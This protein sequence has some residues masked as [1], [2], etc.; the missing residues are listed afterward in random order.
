M[1]KVIVS[2]GIVGSLTIG[3]LFFLHQKTEEAISFLLPIATIE[4]STGDTFSVELYPDEAPNT[5][6]N[7]IY[8]AE[9]GFYTHTRINR[10]VPGFIIQAG[11]PIGNGRGFPGYFIKSECR[12]NGIPNSIKHEKGVLSMARSSQFDT[13]GSQFFITL[14]KSKHLDGQYSAFGKII[15]GMD[16]LEQLS[17]VEVDQWDRPIE[18]VY[19]VDVT[20]ETHAQVYDMPEIISVEET[21]AY[22]R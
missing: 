8:L 15:E 19:I 6:K 17:L 3:Y 14:E 13:E 9:S 7:F 5:V 18:P 10:I 22:D 16:I 12:Y 11:D 1:K 2:V 4:L 21:L 20:I